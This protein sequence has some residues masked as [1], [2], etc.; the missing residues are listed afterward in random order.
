MEAELKK[1]GRD[2]RDTTLTELDVLWNQAK[3]L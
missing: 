3:R 1:R 2:I